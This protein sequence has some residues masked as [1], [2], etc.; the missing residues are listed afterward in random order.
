MYIHIYVYTHI[1]LYIYICM[2]TYIY[3]NIYIYT[4]TYVYLCI[5][6]Y[7][8]TCHALKGIVAV[9]IGESWEFPVIIRT[10][11]HIHPHTS[12]FDIMHNSEFHHQKHTHKYM[13]YGDICGKFWCTR[14]KLF[15]VAV[16]EW[17]RLL[18][19]AHID[20][21]YT[22]AITRNYLI[23]YTFDFT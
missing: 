21:I 7:Q 5:Y 15:F 1:Y 18:R 16:Q 2:Y 9:L 6:V 13:S 11:T 4:C 3:I 20:N 22:N 8:N 23:I 17:A 12:Y 10:N 14:A 19:S